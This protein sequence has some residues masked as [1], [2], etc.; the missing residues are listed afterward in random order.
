MVNIESTVQAIRAAIEQAETMAGVE[1][2]SVYAG[3][4]GSHVAA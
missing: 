4:A 1:I 3:I 2:A